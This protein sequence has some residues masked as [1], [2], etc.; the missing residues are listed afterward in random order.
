MN[1]LSDDLIR[2]LDTWRNADQ[3]VIDRFNENQA[4]IRLEYNL[5]C[6]GCHHII[7]FIFCP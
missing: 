4:D 3:R 7:N 6:K 2:A 1:C 5:S